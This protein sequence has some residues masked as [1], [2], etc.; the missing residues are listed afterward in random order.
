MR[1]GL[2]L[3]KYYLDVQGNDKIEVDK[4]IH[5]S[6]N[7]AL[8]RDAKN[9]TDELTLQLERNVEQFWSN[10]NQNIV[11]FSKKEK[12]FQKADS[13]RKSWGELVEYKFRISNFDETLRRDMLAQ[14]QNV[15]KMVPLEWAKVEEEK[16]KTI[17]EQDPN[18][19][20]KLTSDLDKKIKDMSSYFREK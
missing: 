20:T 12:T 3:D 2:E 1:L 8:Y 18:E 14:T 5:E 16:M 13:I 6:S 17:I 7:F 19:L 10:V 4:R 9:R 15:Q 11:L